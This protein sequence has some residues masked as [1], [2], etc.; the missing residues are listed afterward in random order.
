MVPA[1]LVLE[2]K[3]IFAEHSLNLQQQ[4]KWRKCNNLPFSENALPS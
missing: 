3:K 1:S 4:Q 2:A